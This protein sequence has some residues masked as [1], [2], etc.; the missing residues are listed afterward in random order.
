MESL[1]IRRRLSPWEPGCVQDVG[2]EGYAVHQQDGLL[3]K[4][5]QVQFLFALLGWERQ[6]PLMFLLIYELTQM[7]HCL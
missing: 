4:A 5:G 1:T 7:E 3:S 6:F 2:C